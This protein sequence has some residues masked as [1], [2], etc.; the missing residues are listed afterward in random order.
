MVDL[1]LHHQKIDEFLQ[2]IKDRHEELY[3]R[4]MPME[5]QGLLTIEELKAIYWQF[6]YSGNKLYSVY[7]LKKGEPY[8]IAKEDSGLSRTVNLIVDPVTKD[9]CLMLET[10][11][12]TTAQKDSVL[13]VLSGSY[14]TTKPAWRIDS[15][16]PKKYANSVYYASDEDEIEEAKKEVSVSQKAQFAGADIFT[17]LMIAGAAFNKA[18]VQCV[19]E[20][21]GNNVNRPYQ[22]KISLYSKW[23]NLGDLGAWLKTYPFLTKAQLDELTTQL[24]IAIENFHEKGFVHQDVKLENILVYKDDRG[25]YRLALTDF[26]EV[27]STELPQL[28]PKATYGYESPEISAAHYFWQKNPSFSYDY[29]HQRGT[30]S[31]GSEV[32]KQNQKFY[33]DQIDK[34]KSQFARAHKANDMWAIG[35]VLE[36]LYQSTFYG[37]SWNAK[38]YPLISGLLN[39][40]REKRLTAPQALILAY[41]RVSGRLPGLIRQEFQSG[42][43]EGLNLLEYALIHHDENSVKILLAKNPSLVDHVITKGQYKDYTPLLLSFS[44]SK[45]LII[46]SVLRHALKNT[47][48]YKESLEVGE[49]HCH[50]N[51]IKDPAV[52]ELIFSAVAK[53]KKRPT[54]KINLSNC[55]NDEILGYLRN[56][57]LSK[58]RPF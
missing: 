28:R 44:H 11:S 32:F 40:D 20:S 23:A 49:Y 17:N 36:K 25:K 2:R 9:L 35:I 56:L 29:F 34:Q 27:D 12:K 51:K 31:Y 52:R 1:A 15:I 47:E 6:I 8:R 13:P 7:N 41:I 50:I 37:Q 19:R 42:H 45:P 46:K 10:K 39:P 5:L 55:E 58:R 4:H 21:I 24:L 48:N 26:G 53:Q 14:K 3:S 38:S 43:W 30:V 33:K 57:A 18:G 54:S 16:K 22:K